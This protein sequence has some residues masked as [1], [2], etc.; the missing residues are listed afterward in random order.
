MDE[1]HHPS[2]PL[3]YK[4]CLANALAQRTHCL[5]ELFGDFDW[6]P[7][8]PAPAAAATATSR[9]LSERVACSAA[10]LRVPGGEV[11]PAEALP[12]AQTKEEEAAVEIAA[13]AGVAESVR[14]GEEAAGAAEEAAGAAAG[15]EEGAGAGAGVAHVT[16]AAAGFDGREEAD[17]SDGCSGASGRKASAPMAVPTPA[18]VGSR[19]RADADAGVEVEAVPTPAW[20]CRLSI[21]SPSPPHAVVVAAAAAAVGTVRPQSPSSPSAARA[22]RSGVLSGSAGLVPAAG[23]PMAVLGA[24][25]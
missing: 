12:K 17:G 21:G 24:A 20:K 11:R 25:R 19:W 4:E 15:G 6:Y 2:Q 7:D 5:Q 16:V 3:R 1:L 14:A 8:L 13:A 10:V 23:M 9:V 18:A 22:G